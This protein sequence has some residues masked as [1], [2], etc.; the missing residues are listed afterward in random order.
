MP[1]LRLLRCACCT[2]LGLGWQGEGGSHAVEQRVNFFRAGACFGAAGQRQQRIPVLPPCW[3]LAPPT[4]PHL[5]LL[6]HPR[7][8]P[9]PHGTALPPPQTCESP[10]AAGEPLIDGENGDLVFVVQ[11]QPHPLFERRGDDL[12]HH[13]N[14]TL[15]DALTGFEKQ[16]SRSL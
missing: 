16:V 1:T 14:I 2:Y 11:T 13:A 6:A 15:L 9:S 5:P 3:D 8:P 10:P 4:H 12:W 7:P